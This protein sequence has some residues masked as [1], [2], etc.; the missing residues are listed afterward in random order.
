MIRWAPIAGWEGRYEIS[1]T[2]LV[3]RTVDGHLI[4]RSTTIYGYRVVNLQHPK[5]QFLV[6]RLVGLGF[7]ENPLNKPHINH[8]DNNRSNNDFRNLEWCTPLENIRHMVRQGRASSHKKGLRGHGFKLTDAA[9]CDLR[10]TYARGGVSLVEV[11]EMFGISKRSAG[12]CISRKTYAD[13]L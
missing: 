5:K 2:G 8:I 9:V 6:H 3:R 10:R 13:V 11:G 7:I 12:R 1:D 4:S